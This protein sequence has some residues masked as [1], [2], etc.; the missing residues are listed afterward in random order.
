MPDYDGLLDDLAVYTYALSARQVLA[1][2]AA[3]E[4]P[5]TCE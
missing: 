5:M 1:H 3:G 4:C 2:Y